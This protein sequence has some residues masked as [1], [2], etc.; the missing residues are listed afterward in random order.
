MLLKLGNGYVSRGWVLDFK[1]LRYMDPSKKD[2][3]LE[4]GKKI[5]E[6]KYCYT[7]TFNINGALKSLNKFRGSK[8]NNIIM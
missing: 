5:V 2:P 7:E 6:Y 8:Y 3:N 1:K 4:L